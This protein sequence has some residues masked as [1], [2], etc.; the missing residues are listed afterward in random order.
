MASLL[1]II[2]TMAKRNME[3]Y[4]T[5]NAALKRIDISKKNECGYAQIAINTGHAQKLMVDE[6]FIVVF[7]FTKA[8]YF[9]INAQTDAPPHDPQ[10]IR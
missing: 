3:I 8:D 4:R 7:T 2:A 6:A 10:G 1:D 9:K 5:D